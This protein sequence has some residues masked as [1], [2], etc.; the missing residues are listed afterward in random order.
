MYYATDDHITF[1]QL[2]AETIKEYEARA[3][4]ELHTIAEMIR[5]DRARHPDNPQCRCPSSLSC[6]Q[7][8]LKAEGLLKKAEE[9]KAWKMLIFLAELRDGKDEHFSMRNAYTKAV[10]RR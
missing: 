9:T 7:P 6:N 5:M 4:I 1:D 3:L 2:G 10:M 8:N